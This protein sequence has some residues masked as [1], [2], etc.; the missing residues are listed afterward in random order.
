MS[1]DELQL[2]KLILK[3]LEG[4]ISAEELSRLNDILSSDLAACEIY[5]NTMFINSQISRPGNIGTYL[6]DTDCAPMGSGFD[7]DLW[8]A[9]AESEKAAPEI[10]IP[11]EESQQEL[12][13]KV[14]YP[15]QNKRV[16]SKL[17]MFMLLNT[18]EIL[19][20]LLFLRFGLPGEGMEVATLVDSLNAKWMGTQGEMTH[21]TPIV[22]SNKSLVLREGYAEL[23]FTNQARITIEGP[24]EFQIPTDDQIKL[25]YGRVYAVVPRE[26]IGF[27]IKTPSSQVIDLGTE[28]GV[29]TEPQGDTFHH[30]TKGKTV[31]IAGDK[32]NKKT[33]EVTEGFAKKVS[34]H[35][36]SISEISYNENLFVRKID[37]SHKIVWRG[38]DIDLADIVGGGNGFG[39]GTA[40]SGIETNTG[41]RCARPDADLVGGK[42]PVILI[43]QRKLSSGK[44]SCAG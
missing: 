12:I 19:F 4:E 9:L 5:A 20:F 32:S 13:Q 37:S 10:E 18:A 6:I 22:S 39:T 23:L 41:R 28:F 44:Q 40:D 14:I 30:V 26:A 16:I 33:V 8:R 25:N 27:T 1:P 11:K 15:P 38:Q 17:N 35:D 31:L 42:V 36:R 7:N 34:I 3:C 24:A 43:R 29:W 21:G 2:N